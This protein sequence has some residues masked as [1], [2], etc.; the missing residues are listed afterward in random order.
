MRQSARHIICA[1]LA[2]AMWIAA[3]APAGA[4]ALSRGAID[5][6]EAILGAPS[7][8]AA[9]TAAQ[10]GGASLATLPELVPTVLDQPAPPQLL[11]AVQALATIDTTA[12]L[13]RPDV[14]NSV[15]MP[16]VRTPL[17]DRWSRVE[18]S[19]AST[20]PS[21]AMNKVQAVRLIHIPS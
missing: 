21:K 14:F 17:D 8:L 13:D 2:S 10:S 7:S 1:G 3:A 19:G 11:P 15:A 18:N 5:K 12:S 16:I 20:G 4:Q 9:I 6:S